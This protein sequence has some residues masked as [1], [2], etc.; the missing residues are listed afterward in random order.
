MLVEIF[1][2]GYFPLLI[3]QKI[4]KTNMPVKNTQKVILK[5]I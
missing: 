1:L 3:F 5:I 2:I 4:Q